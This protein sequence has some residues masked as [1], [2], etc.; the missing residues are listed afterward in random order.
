MAKVSPP[1][2][3]VGSFLLLIF[4]GTM[5]LMFLPGFMPG[6]VSW[7]DSLFTSSSA[8]C[9]TGLTVADTATQ[10]TFRGQIFHLILIQLGGL[11]MLAFTSVIIQVLGFRCHCDRSR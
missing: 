10:F 3:F 9:V 8:V 11:G 4:I 7:I 6:T 5:G 2:I 1:Q